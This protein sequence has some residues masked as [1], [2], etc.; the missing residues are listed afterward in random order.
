MTRVACVLG[1]AGLIAASACTEI[2]SPARDLYEVMQLDSGLRWAWLVNDRG[3]VVVDGPKGYAL[4][5]D[6]ETVA[7]SPYATD[8]TPS[9]EAMNDGGQIAGWSNVVNCGPPGSSCEDRALVWDGAF[10]VLGPGHAY[11]INDAGDVVGSGSYFDAD[12]S[13][14]VSEAM[15][16][17]S[18]EAIPLGFQGAA[19]AIN[20]RGQIAGWTF[21]G[22]AFLWELDQLRDLGPGAAIAMNDAGQVLVQTYAGRT[23]LWHD[24][25][26]RD[27]SAVWEAALASAGQLSYRAW[28]P[29]DI[30]DDGWVLVTGG[31]G[32]AVSF[33]QRDSTLIFLDGWATAMN[34]RGEVVGS[35]NHRATIWRLAP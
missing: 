17:R 28:Y 30:N 19:V 33:V 16:W 31:S 13:Y 26:A 7:I 20:N 24:G 3:W 11:G 32:D 14:F 5:R 1:V 2:V 23:M 8:M 9:L 12:S 27:L 10:T 15:L 6:G 34:D 25:V 4:W 22:R 21:E 29:I 18:G 35:R